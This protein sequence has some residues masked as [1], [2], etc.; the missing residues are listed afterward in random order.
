M[1]TVPSPSLRTS[2]YLKEKQE[3]AERKKQEKSEGH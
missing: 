1:N 2:E 3:E